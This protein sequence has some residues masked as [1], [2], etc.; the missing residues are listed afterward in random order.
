MYRSVYLGDGQCVITIYCTQKLYNSRFSCTQYS[1]LSRGYVS[2]GGKTDELTQ[3]SLF[4]VGVRAASMTDWWC[5]VAVWGSVDGS[6][7][8]RGRNSEVSAKV[9][10]DLSSFMLY[11][12][13]ELFITELTTWSIF[14]MVSF[15]GCC[16]QLRQCGKT[17]I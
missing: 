11:R 3:R 13:Y 10:L 2:N 15:Q 9:F 16:I 7:M 14:V 8:G 6:Q 17:H 1:R 12:L 4:P 5:L